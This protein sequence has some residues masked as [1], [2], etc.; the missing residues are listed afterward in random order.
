MSR[1][2][3]YLKF[4]RYLL[5]GC[6]LLTL[7]S[8]VVLYD[9]YQRPSLEMPE[10]W[11][12]PENE[13]ST[14]LNA[15]WWEQLNDSVLNDLVLEAIEN[16]KDIK[17]A[18]A[19][20][21]EFIAR[22]GV[23]S[24]QLYPQINAQGSALR[25]RT[26]QTLAGTQDFGS[27]SGGGIFPF[28]GNG[29]FPFFT[30]VSPYANDYRAVINA[31][32]QL[33]LF[34]KIRSATDASIAEMLAQA[35]NQRTVV[36]TIVSNVATAYVTLRQYDA[37]LEISLKTLKSREESYEL[38]KIRFEEGL[39]SE[40]EVKQ[41][42]SEVDEAIIQVI[43]LQYLI[44]VQENLIS[45]LI[46]HPPDLVARGRSID[47]W[48]LPI[49]IPAGLPADLLE[50]RPDIKEAEYQLVAA[51]ATIGEARAQFF[52]DITLT[53]Y[54]GYESGQLHKLFIDPSRTWQ[55]F[56]NL[57]Q[58]IFEGGR[59]I[60]NLDL[61]TAIK[62][63]AYYNYQQTVL[64]ALK[65]A[66]D[67][68]IAYEQS[69]K[70]VLAEMQRVK[71]LTDYLKLATLQYENGLV[72]YLNV[73][74]AERRLFGAQLDL[75]QAQAYVFTSLISIYQALGGGWVSDADYLATLAEKSQCAN[76]KPFSH[77]LNVRSKIVT[78]IVDA[79]DEPEC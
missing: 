24:S 53:G 10:K 16:N 34:G 69:K 78:N 11:R 22:V 76:V 36:L 32:Y 66:N 71:D 77:M 12:L 57:L 25:Q 67:A 9:R 17:I 79:T 35:E 47:E 64:T 15:K 51:N 46:G 3:K 65:E 43:Q 37:Q 38:A 58:P 70:G 18:I 8:C 42:A 19:R 59:L 14:S 75:A 50:Q 61:T 39:T 63:Q 74:D 23:I 62:R 41:A 2:N 49:D 4:S 21:D 31:S 48:S 73:L 27:S 26:S 33:D 52:P 44:P 29:V 1:I 13:E 68:F 7:H 55:I 28:P 30:P 54:Y 6:S 40:L 72:D 56:G 20:V 45:V 5:F 60:S